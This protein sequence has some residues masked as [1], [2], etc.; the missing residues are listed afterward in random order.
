VQEVRRDEGFEPWPRPLE[1]VVDVS[2][3][4]VLDLWWDGRDLF[5]DSGR[6]DSMVVG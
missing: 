6:C 4:E 1:R 2:D 3:D 5:S